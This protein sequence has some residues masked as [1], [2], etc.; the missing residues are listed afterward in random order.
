GRY[1]FAGA[2]PVAGGPGV[3]L[4]VGALGSIK[5]RTPLVNGQIQQ[6]TDAGEIFI[7][8]DSNYPGLQVP[9]SLAG[10]SFPQARAGVVAGLGGTVTLHGLNANSPYLPSELVP[11][12]PVLIWQDRANTTLKYTSAGILDRS[13]GSIC[14]NILSVPGSQQMV[15][16]G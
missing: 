15:I 11:Y 4:T 16:Q 6:N 7:F 13:C 12:A 5:D 10:L 14:S 1:V 8:T 3:G 9:T 2:Q